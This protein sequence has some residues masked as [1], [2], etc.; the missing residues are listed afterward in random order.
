MV[1]KVIL[2][3]DGID[4]GYLTAM[5]RSQLMRPSQNL[6]KPPMWCWTGAT[7][8]RFFDA[9]QKE[10]KPGRTGRREKI[11]DHFRAQSGSDW[12]L[13]YSPG[14]CFLP[15]RHAV[16]KHFRELPGITFIEAS[17]HAENH[18]RASVI[19]KQQPFCQQKVE[20]VIS[21]SAQV[22]SRSFHIN[23]V[24]KWHLLTLLYCK[25]K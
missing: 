24:S 18:S 21:V 17:R 8:R 2:Y 5:L 11:R 20:S 10:S 25:V 7:H 15:R 12:Y 9:R 13:S 22:A 1:S 16:C 19:Q 4:A 14:T 3:P 23:M 6:C